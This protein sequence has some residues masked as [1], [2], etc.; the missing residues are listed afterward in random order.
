MLL[1][2]NI[3][4]VIFKSKLFTNRKF[5]T[6]LIFIII[7]FYSL[8]VFINVFFEFKYCYFLKTKNFCVF[9]VKYV[10]I[11][12]LKLKKRMLTIF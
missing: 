6:I 11:V 2:S 9:L 12:V 3:I 5:V 1:S 8:F 4:F 7:I 10:K